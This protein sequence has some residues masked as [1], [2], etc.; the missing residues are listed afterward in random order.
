MQWATTN[1]IPYFGSV[2]DDD[3]TKWFE[4]L[5]IGMQPTEETIGCQGVKQFLKDVWACLADMG[6]EIAGENQED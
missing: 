2:I 6:F 3:L 1:K 5:K 4:R